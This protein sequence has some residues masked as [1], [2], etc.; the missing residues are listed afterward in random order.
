MS[1]FIVRPFGVKQTE[2]GEEIDFNAI[3]QKLITPALD[4]L[5]LKG[6]TTE[7]IVRAGNI[8][9]DMFEELLTADLVIDATSGPKRASA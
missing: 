1:V 3:E 5:G 8:R 6:G 4:E 2:N 7:L 9:A